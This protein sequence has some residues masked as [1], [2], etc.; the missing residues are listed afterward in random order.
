MV[1]YERCGSLFVPSS[2]AYPGAPQNVSANVLT[3]TSIIV[4]W[5]SPPADQ[6]Y[7][8]V[9][10]YNISCKS[11][12]L[13]YNSSLPSNVTRQQVTGLLPY[14]TYVCS[15]WAMNYHG[16]GPNASITVTTPPS[17]NQVIVIF[18]WLPAVVFTSR[19]ADSVSSKLLCIR[20]QL[21]EHCLEMEPTCSHLVQWSSS[22]LLH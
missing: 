21:N 20:G 8:T 11:P 4:S 9:L 1:A 13:T 14:T 19:R 6:T 18:L 7:G 16:W 3:S 12:G 5:R 10:Q 22:Q 2:P 15:V 17:G